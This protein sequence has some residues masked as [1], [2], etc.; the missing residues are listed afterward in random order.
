MRKDIINQLKKVYDA[1][2]NAD[3]TNESRAKPD[4]ILRNQL[5]TIK[6]MIEELLNNYN[7]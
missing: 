5:I 7:N 3:D 1:I 4:P 2:I 6:Q